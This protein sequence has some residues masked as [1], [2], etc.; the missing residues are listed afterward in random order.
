MPQTPNIDE[1]EMDFAALLEES[2][3]RR[4]PEQGDI[5]DGTILAIDQQGLLVDVGLKKDGVVTKQDLERLSE[6]VQFEIGQ[7]V[8]VVIVRLNGSGGNLIVSVSQ[9]AHA[10]DWERAEQLMENDEVF[11]GTIVEANRGGIIVP[12]GHLRGFVPASHLTSLPRGISEQDR[13]MQLKTL[14]GQSIQAKVIEV[15]RRR[16][17][18]VFSQREAMREH[19]TQ[20]K[21]RLM[22]ELSEGEVREGMVSGLRDFGAFVDLGGADGLV[23]ISELAWHRVQH[24]SEVVS[25]GDKVQVYVMHL[26]EKDRR[27]GLSLK[28]LQENPWS[29]I[30]NLYHIGQLV[31]GKVSRIESYGVF[32]HLEPGIEALLHSTQLSDPAP[33]SL[34]GLVTPG[35]E[36]LVRIISIEPERQRLGLS[37]REV[38]YNERMNWAQENGLDPN[39]I[40]IEAGQSN[41]NPVLSPMIEEIVAEPTASSH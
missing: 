9:A 25:V 39:T 23:H 6:N 14:I 27:I 12:F 29:S 34:D 32:V 16:R 21:E 40:T 26:D 38:T 19:R 5:V 11:T 10:E 3:K 31:L 15:N 4:M 20:I 28:R 24:P 18:L 13:Q 33:D 22:N 1:S 30:D 37:L 2:F 41:E 35:Q 17:R 8:P 36:L 7:E